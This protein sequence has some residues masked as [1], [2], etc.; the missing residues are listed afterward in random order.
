MVIC[1]FPANIAAH[2]PMCAQHLRGGARAAPR[3][4]RRG[5]ARLR[6]SACVFACAAVSFGCA[7][8][9]RARPFLPSRHR[10]GIIYSY[11]SSC[12]RYC[13][14]Q[15]HTVDIPRS[16]S[17][18]RSDILGYYDNGSYRPLRGPVPRAYSTCATV[19]PT[20]EAYSFSRTRPRAES[21]T[22]FERTY[23]T[24]CCTVHGMLLAPRPLPFPRSRRS[25]VHARR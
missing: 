12:I 19:L 22:G 1:L 21:R 14:Y 7:T 11:I 9:T 16:G 13:R 8:R 2:R 23:A 6:A 10:N 17:P 15:R 25:T 5:L 3:G 4:G 20:S 18:T 24:S